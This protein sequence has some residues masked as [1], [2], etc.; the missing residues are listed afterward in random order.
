ME[1]D[2]TITLKIERQYARRIDKRSKLDDVKRRV[3]RALPE[4]WMLSG[5]TI[6]LRTDSMKAKKKRAGRAVKSKAA[7]VVRRAVAATARKLREEVQRRQRD[8]D[9]STWASPTFDGPDRKWLLSVLVG[10]GMNRWKVYRENTGRN[11]WSAATVK[12][13]S[14]NPTLRKE[15]KN[16]YLGDD[17]VAD[18][19][20]AIGARARAYLLKNGCGPSSVPPLQLAM[21]HEVAHYRRWRTRSSPAHDKA[22]QRALLNL[23]KKY[24]PK[25]FTEEAVAMDTLRGMR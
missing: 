22:W 13:K 5:A 7:T 17:V 21:L 23:L 6:N 12:T 2:Y 16:L 3:I 10:E 4:G 14:G 18:R 1:R 11:C 25:A 24:V 9:K 19:T 20:M 15:H 8:F